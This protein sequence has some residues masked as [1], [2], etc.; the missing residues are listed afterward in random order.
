MVDELSK[1]KN[2]Q[3]Y[4]FSV[5]CLTFPWSQTSKSKLRDSFVIKEHWALPE[6]EEIKTNTRMAVVIFRME[7]L[8]SFACWT[9]LKIQMNN[10]PSWVV[11]ELICVTFE[12]LSIQFNGAKA[13]YQYLMHYSLIIYQGTTSLWPMLQILMTTTEIPKIWNKTSQ[14]SR[15]YNLAL[16]KL[17][18][19]QSWHRCRTVN[20]HVAK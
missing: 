19:Y 8:H 18:T 15:A 9:I 6:K 1:L 3:M 20:G 2:K 5:E 7:I 16:S 17:C 11:H 14:Q 10:K 13:R 4:Y 12:V